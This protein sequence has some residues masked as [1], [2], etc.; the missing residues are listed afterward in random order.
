M[1][2][3][4]GVNIL[5]KNLDN[6]KDKCKTEMIDLKRVTGFWVLQRDVHKVK[7]VTEVKGSPFDSYYTEEK[8]P[9]L[10]LDYSTL[11]LIHTL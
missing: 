6:F 7:L 10:S 1:V 3:R 11:P 8:G 5:A 4:R 2:P 9:L